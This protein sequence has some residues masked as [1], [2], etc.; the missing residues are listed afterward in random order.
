MNNKRK[1][2][3]KKEIRQKDDVGVFHTEAL[4]GQYKAYFQLAHY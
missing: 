2:R 4:S 1:M 3:K